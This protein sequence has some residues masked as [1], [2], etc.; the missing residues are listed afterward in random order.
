MKNLPEVVDA[1]E[2]HGLFTA[3]LLKSLGD[4]ETD[5]DGDGAIQLSELIDEVSWRVA[6][7]SKGA[8][9]P[10][11][12]RRELFGDFAIGDAAKRR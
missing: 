3:A 2:G 10:W 6:R 11:V 8:Q 7:S 5:R 1:G 9:T 12:A 4:Q